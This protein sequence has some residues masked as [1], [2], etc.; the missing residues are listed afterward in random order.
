LKTSLY[1]RHRVKQKFKNIA[2][3]L[4]LRDNKAI[5]SAIKKFFKHLKKYITLLTYLLPC[6]AS[7]YQSQVRDL[8]ATLLLHHSQ[9]HQYCL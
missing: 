1:Y 5:N 8:Q 6:P 7:F 2:I 4:S 9:F 3:A